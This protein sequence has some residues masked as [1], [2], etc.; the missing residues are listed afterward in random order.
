LPP[1]GKLG[2]T[3]LDESENRFTKLADLR[4]PQGA[5]FTV[6]QFLGVRS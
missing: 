2:A 3:V 5:Q 6:S 1:P 4:D